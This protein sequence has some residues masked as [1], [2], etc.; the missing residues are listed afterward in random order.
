M[1]HVIEPALSGRA[2]CRDSVIFRINEYGTD[3]VSEECNEPHYTPISL[4][5]EEC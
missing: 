3:L 4:P 2:K 5:L 1:P